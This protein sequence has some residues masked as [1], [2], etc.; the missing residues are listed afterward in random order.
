M[1]YRNLGRT[2]LRVSAVCMGTMT[3]GYQTEPDEAHRILDAAAEGGVTFYDCADVY[4]LGSPDVG[5]SEEILGQ[6]MAKRPRD[7]VVLAT[8]CHAAMG[9]GQND[10]GNSRAHILNA[11]DASLRRLGTDYIDLYQLHQPDPRTPIEETMQ[12]LDDLVRWGK[13]RYVG[14]SNFK[15]WQLGMAFGASS[16]LGLSRF[17]CEQPRYN[18]LYR[19]AED[20]LLPLARAEGL[21]IIAYN[22][23]AGGFLTGKYTDTADLREGTRFMLGSAAQRYQDRYWHDEDF[24]QVARLKEYFAQRD[25]GLTH[26]A[27]A[28][29][30]AQPGVTSAIVGASRAGQIQDSLKALEVELSD[31]DLEACDAVWYTLPRRRP[32]A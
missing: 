13:V 7:S 18:M 10:R 11:V 31:A 1:E 20:E 25:I 24:R 29:V 12:A 22:P 8:K 17:E 26:A 28:W 30:L 9:P 27:I 19:A 21:G 4:P 32:V 16:R 5:T 15:A 14:T 6:W 23:L 2:G 3:F